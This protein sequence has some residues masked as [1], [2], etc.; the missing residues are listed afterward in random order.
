MTY[1][2]DGI[3]SVSSSDEAPVN[4]SD[5]RAEW[6][7]D[8]VLVRPRDLGAVPENAP[9]QDPLGVGFLAAVLRQRGHEVVVL[10][11]HALGVDDEGLLTYLAQLTPHVVGLSLHSF[12]D[13]SHCVEISAKLRSLPNPP[14]CV[15]GGEHATFH[16]ENILR[17]H[18]EVDAVVLGEGEET[19]CE[20]V[21]RVLKGRDSSE[22]R[23]TSPPPPHPMTGVSDQPQRLVTLSERSTAPTLTSADS[24]LGAAVRGRDGNILHGGFRPAIEDLDD[25]P[26]AHKDSVE[27]ALRMGK[28]VSVSVLTGR[29]CTAKCRFCTANEFMRLGGGAVWRRR[30]PK[31]VA[32]EVERL[33]AKYL[34]HPLVHPV[35]Q[36]QDVIFLGTSPASKRWIRDYVEEIRRRNLRV[37]F[38]CMA[39]ADAII[40]NRDMLPQLVEIG[41]WSV[42]VGIESGVDRILQSYNK[43]NS[44]NENEHA[45]ELP[46]SCGVTFDASGFIMFD[47]IMT[48]EELRLNARY[49]SRFGAA[50][51][52][53]FVTRLQLYPGTQVRDEMIRKGLFNRAEDIGCTSDYAFED[54]IVGIVA[55]HA[56]YYNQS[57]WALDLALRDAKAALANRLRQKECSN[58]PLS[59]AVNLVHETY[60]QHLLVLADL[61]ET[62]R[63]ETEFE[64]LIIA[65][66]EKVQMLTSLLH[67]LLKMEGIFRHANN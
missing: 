66:L 21:E 31:A 34:D 2:P 24:I 20:I 30:S 17:Q 7:P 27:M 64:E 25:L 41:L 13:Y 46:R 3:S 22:R 47:P 39:R 50:T 57:I 52:N 16:A 19:F 37:P 12:S 15:W 14:Y 40:A 48:V 23:H 6:I 29:G 65:F 4:Q 26:A 58:G 32:D 49:L 56:Y 59:G 67:D 45:V 5:L 11:A 33:A 63:I 1:S 60:C 42:E 10:D 51:W 18:Y 44:A 54:P 28:P 53:F 8:V 38:Y 43:H 36:F 35:L 9:V 55:D 62:G 61:A